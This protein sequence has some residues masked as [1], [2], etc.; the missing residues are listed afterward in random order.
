MLLHYI[1]LLAIC[2]EAVSGALMGI[3]KDMDI[4]GIC[5]IGTVAALGGGTVRDVLIGHYPLGWVAHPEYLA[6]TICAA[7]VAAVAARALHHFKSAFLV[8]DALG[9]VAFTIIGCDI[10]RG[11]SSFHP[12]IVVLLGMVTGVFGGLLRDVLCNEIPLVLRRE[13]YASVSLLTGAMYVGILHLG[14]A[15]HI[16]TLSSL[17]L[18]CAVRLLA[19]R[20]H[21]ELPRLNKDRIRGFD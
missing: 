17:L 19:I 18:G 20:F 21:W 2:A 15:P 7:V 14:I 1:Y 8:V 9:L 11:F 16:A 5:L 4:F 13:I 12:A 10:A 3:R 6:F